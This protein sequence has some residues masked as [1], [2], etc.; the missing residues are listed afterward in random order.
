MKHILILGGGFG[1]V[2]MAERLSK[3]LGNTDYL[4][5]LVS[6]RPDFTF[7]PALVRFAFG[8]CA[9]EEIKFDL[10]EKCREIGVRFV[11]GEV[12]S[13]NTDRKTVRVTGADIDGELHYD[14]LVI[15]IGRRLATEKVGGF[16]EHAHHLLGV[17]AA[18]KFGAEVEAFGKGKIVCGLAPDALLP[19]PVC[20]TAFALAERFKKKILTGDISVEVVFPQSVKEAFGGAE[21][22]RKLER[23]FQ[24]H[25]IKMTTDFAV[26][27]IEKNEIISTDDRKISYDLLMLAPPFRGQTILGDETFSNEK[28]FVKVDNFC[29]VEN[30]D[31]TYAVGDITD[32]PGPKL[33]YMAI[34]QAQAAA[35]NIL[36]ETR[37]EMPVKIYHHDLAAIVDEGGDEAMFLHYGIWDHT[38]YGIKEGKMWHRIKN[39]SHGLTKIQ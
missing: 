9:E 33:A 29:R 1:G 25:N 22:H 18:Q 11:E 8:D 20:E 10:Y 3:A 27:E 36:S 12:I 26:S 38:L 21:V 14:Y 13:M 31:N 5:T 2:M 15:A 4:I 23:A 39:F 32:F 24:S 19:V 6:K 37:G 34:R 30:L 28:G 35:E 17:K 16:F 7:Y